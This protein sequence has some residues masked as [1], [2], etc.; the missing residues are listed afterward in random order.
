MG[1]L[2][3]V[4]IPMRSSRRLTSRKCHTTSQRMNK[5]V[6]AQMVIAH[7]PVKKRPHHRQQQCPLPFQIPL[8]PPLTE[9]RLQFPQA[10]AS[11]SETWFRANVLL[12]SQSFAVHTWGQ[13]QFAVPSTEEVK[14]IAY[15]LK[16]ACLRIL[17]E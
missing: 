11:W 8:R 4:A 3:K 2:P 10:P 17:V 7:A 6:I 9:R 14:P 15:R 12:R 13:Q 1:G 5:L 16:F